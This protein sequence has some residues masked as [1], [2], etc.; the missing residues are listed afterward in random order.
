MT[1][2]RLAGQG[3]EGVGRE[4]ER[5]TDGWRMRERYWECKESKGVCE[6]ADEQ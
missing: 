2:E 1:D 5:W 6:Q 4:G 3:G